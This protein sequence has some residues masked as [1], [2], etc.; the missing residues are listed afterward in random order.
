MRSEGTGCKAGLKE[1]NFMSSNEAIKE[2]IK[3]ET[4]R[5]KT[6]V[7]LL[8]VLGGGNYGLLTIIHYN[9][10]NKVLFIVGLIFNLFIAILTLYSYFTTNKLLKNLKE[11]E[12]K[13]YV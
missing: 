9:L 12:D 11:L 8:I 6:Y 1:Q 2:R 4:E 13:S 10:I 5:F 3:V 7:L